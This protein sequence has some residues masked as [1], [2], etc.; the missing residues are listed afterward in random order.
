[1]VE[2]RSYV[3]GGNIACKLEFRI[4]FFG[5][6]SIRNEGTELKNKFLLKVFKCLNISVKIA[7][8]YKKRDIS[9]RGL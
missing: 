8:Q 2:Q 4:S 1:M 9:G 5:R 7:T 3:I 6:Y